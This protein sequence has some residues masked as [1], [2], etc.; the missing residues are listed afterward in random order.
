VKFGGND[1]L[2]A[3][4]PAAPSP[5]GPTRTSEPL[6]TAADPDPVPNVRRSGPTQPRDPKRYQIIGEHGRGGLGR[7]SRAHDHDLGRDIAIKE[8]ISRGHVSEVRFLRE[9]LITARLEHPGIVPIYEAGRW[10]DGTPFYAMKLVAGRSLRELITERTTVE[11]RIGLLHHV[12]A[13]ADAI[14]YAHGRNIIHRDLKP[15]NVIVGDFGE[16][17]VIDW[18]LAKDLTAAEESTVGGGPFRVN[19]D[20]GLTSAGSVLGT[21]T[22]MAPEQERGEHVDQRADVFAIGAM[23]W[24]LCSLQK[25][26]PTEPHLRHRMLRR[27]GIDRDLIT[28]IDKALDPD[29]GRRYAD[30]GALAADLKAFKS[31]VRIAA[32][33][34]SLFAMLAH[35]TR[36]HRTLAL[37][38]AAV[39]AAVL[40]G[41]VAYVRNIAIERDRADM[42]LGLVE[43]TKNDLAVE[44]ADL[45]LKHAQLLLTSDPSAAL[46]SLATYHGVNVERASQLRAEA[47]GRGVAVVRAIPHTD[48]IV[49]AMGTPDRS[50]ISLSIDGTI[51]RTSSDQTSVI[52]AR[53]AAS[54]PVWSYEPSRHLLAYA[55]DPADLCILD[56]V[57]GIRIPTHVNF[58]DVHLAGASF[59][60][61]GTQLALI[62]RAG[63]VRVFDVALP[64]QPVERLHATID[65]GHAVLF[66]DEYTIAVGTPDGLK[67]VR[68]NGNIQTLQIANGSYW[69]ADPIAHQ[70]ALAT[71]QGQGFL[72]ETEHLNIILH[73]TLCHEAVSGLSFIPGRHAVAYACKDGTIGIWNLQGAVVVPKAHLEGHADTIVASSGGDYLLA[74]GGNGILAVLDLY[75]DLVTSYKGHGFRLTAITP[76]TVEYPLIL[77]ADVRG[78]LRA[79]PLPNRLARAVANVHTRFLSAIFDTTTSTLIAT[80]YAPQ[81]A[82]YTR[83]TGVRSVVPHTNGATFLEGAANGRT[84]ATFGA[85]ESVE[86]WSFVTMS[87]TQILTHHSSISHVSFIGHSDDFVTSDRDGELMQWLATGQHKVIARFGQPITTF[88]ITAAGRTMIIA[89][90]D[91]ALWKTDNDGAVHLMRP[92]GIQVTRMLPSADTTSVYVGYANGDVVVIDAKLWTQTILLRA[93][94]AVSDIALTPDGS[95]VAVATNDGVIRIGIRHPGSRASVIN[96]AELAARARQIALAPDGL[97]MAACID[98]TVRLYFPANRTTLCLTTGTA[99]L[100]L[101]LV[102]ADGRTGAV[103]DAEGR[104]ILVDLDVIR[105]TLTQ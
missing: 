99:D 41:I 53:G 23:L 43:E 76:P 50:I 89:T 17:I 33:S 15:A 24:E 93:A 77:T 96:W 32:R 64:A 29:P 94:A 7:V 12:I 78:G 40:S 73:D 66:V 8:L 81:L 98:G 28:I 42:A 10:P 75:T 26:P 91:G 65:Y 34:Y 85:S 1:G 6:P 55:C 61:K 11:K 57:Q 30:A 80:T 84:F 52:L 13:V 69:E 16:T 102:A 44:H 104:I 27:A 79:W 2:S 82:I 100:T 47:V 54:W 70:I 51:A 9:A 103:L 20:D 18:G 72:V 22:Y 92:G 14:A 105:S 31:G 88:A 37:S 74:A 4:Q 62:S 59:S 83:L 46:D 5:V 25:V 86:L 36:R 58:H 67:L 3:T 49:W 90:A 39:V 97:L 35:W 87:R 68:M 71:T 48:N 95:T 56:I 60:P 38:V 45:T 19:Q 101:A 63:V 21:P